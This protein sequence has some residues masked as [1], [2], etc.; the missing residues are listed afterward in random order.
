[1][2]DVACSE[3]ISVQISKRTLSDKKEIVCGY[4]EKMKAELNE[5]KLEIGSCREVIRVLQ[6]EI[7]EISPSIQPTGNKANEDYEDEES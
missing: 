1:M 2:A 6:E 5:V 7:R 4:C 3:V